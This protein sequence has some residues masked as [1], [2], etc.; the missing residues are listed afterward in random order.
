MKLK[1]IIFFLFI[2]G[3]SLVSRSQFHTHMSRS[4]VGLLLGGMYYIGDLNRFGHFKGTQPAGG[5]LYR[6]NVN[7]RL[8]FRA[9][10]IYG[11]VVGDDAWSKETL[12]KNRNLSFKSEIFEL[13]A[14]VEFH[15][16]PFQLGSSKYR[17]TAYLLVQIAGFKMNPATMYNDEL[18]YLQPIGT[19]GQG[20]T[21]NSKGR[22]GL[23]QMS[24]PLGVGMKLALGRKSS[25]GIEYGI[26]KT[27]TDYLDDV[28]ADTYLD[29][30]L[31]ANENGPLAATLA[32][33]SLDGN[34]Y[35]KRG[36]ATTKDWYSFF[37][38]T[39]TFRLGDPSKCA[40]KH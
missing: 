3:C 37:A 29:P 5:L 33:R 38:M 2:T 17:G 28:G 6:Y 13:A 31:L 15:Y 25:I 11:N 1:N 9:N 34:R 14:G 21:L 35:G 27:F 23:Y 32:N 22:Y 40:F 30:T 26:R 8:A 12:L 39:F 4:E 18:I 10:F 20:T 16:M 36:T 7:S 24:I 19:E